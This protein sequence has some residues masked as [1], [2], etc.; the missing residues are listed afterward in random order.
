MRLGILLVLGLLNHVVYLCSGGS[1]R[2]ER[3]R[4]CMVMIMI[5][6]VSVFM[7]KMRRGGSS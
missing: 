3:N 6:F 4:M 5:M 7:V 2:R 1:R